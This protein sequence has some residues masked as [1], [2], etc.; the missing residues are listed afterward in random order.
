M[1]SRLP[2]RAIQLFMGVALLLAAAF[3]AMSNLGAFPAGGTALG[4]AG[5]RFPWRLP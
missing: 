1:V 5:W 4:L 3:F 2:R